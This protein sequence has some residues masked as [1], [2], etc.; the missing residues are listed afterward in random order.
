MKFAFVALISAA[1][2]V[3]LEKDVPARTHE[4]DEMGYKLEAQETQGH[5]NADVLANF[6]DQ[7]VQ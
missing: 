5:N 7:Y 6:A 1:T 2:A 4:Y 3:R